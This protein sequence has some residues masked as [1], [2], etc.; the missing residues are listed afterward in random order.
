MQALPGG[1]AS[2]AAPP[3]LPD[4]VTVR[5]GTPGGVPGEGT[6]CNPHDLGLRSSV[7]WEQTSASDS[8]LGLSL[9]YTHPTP[10]HS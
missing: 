7:M 6:P 5:A 10:S 4:A 8:V 9:F 1:R 3:V 2:L